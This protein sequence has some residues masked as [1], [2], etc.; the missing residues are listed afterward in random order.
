MNVRIWICWPCSG[1]DAL[2]RGGRRL[3]DRHRDG[4]FR[5]RIAL[6]AGSLLS[7]DGDEVARAAVD[8]LDGDLLLGLRNEL[9]G[10]G[11]PVRL[12]W[13][14]H[15]EEVLIGLRR[16]GEV[17]QRP[18]GVWGLG[19][20]LDSKYP[21]LLVGPQGVCRREDMDVEVGIVGCLGGNDILAPEKFFPRGVKIPRGGH[22]RGNLVPDNEVVG[23]LRQQEMTAPMECIGGRHMLA[24]RSGAIRHCIVHLRTGEEGID[25]PAALEIFRLVAKDDIVVGD[26]GAVPLDAG[27]VGAGLGSEGQ[28]DAMAEEI[29]GAEVVPLVCDALTAA[30]HEDHGLV[31]GVEL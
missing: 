7:A 5:R 27:A 15:G 1:S 22:R 9:S 6:E 21:V 12:P 8:N 13:M 4:D 20:V 16:Y 31:G 19:M 17:F 24:L 10:D 11:R 2:C 28:W 3:L 26:L 29:N 18:E 30:A 23:I 14:K 25:L